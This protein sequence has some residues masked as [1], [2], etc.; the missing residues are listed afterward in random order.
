M[1]KE[2]KKARAKKKEREEKKEENE[3]VS[4][5]RRC[6]GSVFSE[7]FD[8]VSQGVDSERCG[9]LS[10]GDLLAVADDSSDW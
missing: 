1:D 9:R 6:V 2:P 4:V 7:T 10:R 8:I 5:K 3:T